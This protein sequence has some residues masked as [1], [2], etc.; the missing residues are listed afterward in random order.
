M[1]ELETLKKKITY[2]SKYRGTK[3]MDILLGN[4]VQSCI[5]NLNIDELN[6]LDKLLNYEDFVLL[7][8]HR[9]KTMIKKYDNLK[10]ID[11]FINFKI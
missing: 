3:E 6:D 4:F 11:L 1:N 9:N 5:N 2:R 8:L 10:L 7:N